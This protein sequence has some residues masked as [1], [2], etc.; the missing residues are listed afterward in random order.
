M[1]W[2]EALDLDVSFVRF[3]H[4]HSSEPHCPFPSTP[5]RRLNLE[6]AGQLTDSDRTFQSNQSPE[7][8][9]EVLANTLLLP[10]HRTMARMHEGWL[11]G[12]LLWLRNLRSIIRASPP[13]FLVGLSVA[14]A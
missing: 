13:L 1:Q 11:L 10:C 6:R 12:C 5:S 2:S 7:G 8:S 4:P 3:A 9:S 14:C